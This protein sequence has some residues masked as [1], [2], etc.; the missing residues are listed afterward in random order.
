[1]SMRIDEW[2]EINNMVLSPIPEPM[3]QEITDLTT[4][5]KKKGVFWLNE[6][7]SQGWLLKPSPSA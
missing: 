3:E 7:A 1:M 4:K 2:F 6:V 5:Q